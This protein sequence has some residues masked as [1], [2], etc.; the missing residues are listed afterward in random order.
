MDHQWIDQKHLLQHPEEILNY[1]RVP[2]RSES[3]RR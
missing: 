1:C 2:F 3:W